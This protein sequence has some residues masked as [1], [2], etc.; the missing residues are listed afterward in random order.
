[1]LLSDLSIKRPV[2]ASVLALLLVAF[3]V[4]LITVGSLYRAPFPV[5][6]MKASGA[7]AVSQASLAA[8]LGSAAV[9]GVLR[10]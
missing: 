10:S 7:A 6:P 3:G 9:I 8:G 2:F 4:A 1:M 5:Q